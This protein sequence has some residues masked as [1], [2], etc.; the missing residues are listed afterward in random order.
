VTPT[1]LAIA[2]AGT[3]AST[4]QATAAVE[5]NIGVTSNY[6]WRGTT[7]AN[8][9]AAV[10][11]GLD[12]SHD[13]GIYVGTWASSIGGGN[14]ELDLYAGFSAESGPLGYDVGVITY[15]YPVGEVESDFTEL[16]ANVSYDMFSAGIAY[17]IS[18]ED[19]D[20]GDLY[21]SAGLDFDIDEAMGVSV[22][23]GS[24]NFDND[25]NEDYIHYGAALAKGDF[26]FAI[27]ATDLDEPA[28]DPRVSVS[29]GT[30]F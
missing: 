25:A 13:T 15:L 2:I 16:Y 18:A 17:E 7:Q 19:D 28:D 27:D 30:T 12:Y 14:Y 22:Y 21:Y 26:T 5:G 1:V 3:L 11:G 8:D 20:D 23:V 4:G 6:I 9:D 29:W 10:S 24:Y